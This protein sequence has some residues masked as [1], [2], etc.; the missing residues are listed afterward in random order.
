MQPKG[1]TEVANHKSNLI[2]LLRVSAKAAIF[3]EST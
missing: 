1:H 2:L 3:M